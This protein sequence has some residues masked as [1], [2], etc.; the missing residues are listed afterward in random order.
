[1]NEPEIDIKPIAPRVHLNGTSRDVLLEQLQNSTRK[2]YDAL[3]GLNESWPNARDYYINGFPNDWD[4]CGREWSS[5]RARIL[6]VIEELEAIQEDV[7]N[8]P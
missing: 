8:Q 7:A 6:S 5:R 2:C 3:T 4:R 1:M